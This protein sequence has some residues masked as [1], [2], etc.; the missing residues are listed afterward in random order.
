MGRFPGPLGHIKVKRQRQ[1]ARQVSL[2]RPLQSQRVPVTYDIFLF[3]ILIC[4]ISEVPLRGPFGRWE[5]SRP[6][7]KG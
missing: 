5:G 7:E 6:S 3:P 1:V 2:Q 4:H